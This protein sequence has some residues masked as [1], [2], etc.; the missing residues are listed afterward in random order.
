MIATVSSRSPLAD[1]SYHSDRRG[2]VR[3]K[4]SAVPWLR[5]ARLRYGCD[6][7]V[8]D[9]SNT[10]ILVESAQP[11]KPGAALVLELSGTTSTVIVPARVVR[12]RETFVRDQL[13][14]RAACL[15][16]G[17][18]SMPVSEGET[19]ADASETVQTV[20]GIA[21]A[22]EF[23][24]PAEATVGEQTDAS[25]G[26]QKIVV[27]YR[28]GKLLR[29][30]TNNFSASRSQL[31]VSKEPQG[32]ESVFVPVAQLK[33]IFFVRTFEGDP[34]YVEKTTFSARASGR[35]I[36]VTFHDDEV[37]VGSTLSYR[38]DGQGFFVYPADLKS[39]NVRVFVVLGA[40]R[41]LRFL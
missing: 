32:G 38:H 37:L 18:L 31:H 17:P 10:G 35:K 14:Y 19:D 13:R 15:F 30:H 28:D 6:V 33:A 36:E 5:G 2:Q 24:S 4:P 3:L 8:I 34:W 7:H 1:R 12:C 40:V 29:G 22:L 11:L 27:K 16:T 20:D 21:D 9:I 39:N 26:G 23:P 25:K 41:H